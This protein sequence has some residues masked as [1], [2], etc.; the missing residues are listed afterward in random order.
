MQR[1]VSVSS[2]AHKPPRP[3][4]RIRASNMDTNL[5]DEFRDI[6]KGE[7]EKWKIKAEQFVHLIPAVLLLCLLILYICSSVPF[8]GDVSTLY[9]YP[10]R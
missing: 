4:S 2:S 10:A 6:E 1:T 7:K 5:R 8:Q 3:P 9:F